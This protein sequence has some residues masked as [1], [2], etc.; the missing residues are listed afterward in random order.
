MAKLS[1]PH[2]AAVHDVGDHEGQLYIA[3]E[4]V[5]GR[6]LGTWLRDERPGLW[7]LLDV[8]AQAGRGLAAAHAAGL[9]HRDFKPAN[10]MVSGDG[11]VRVLDFGLARAEVGPH[12]DASALATTLDRLDADARA[13]TH[14]GAIVGTPAYM[15]PEQL[16]GQPATARSDQFAFCVALFEVLHGVRPFAGEDLAEL[17]ANVITGRRREVPRDHVPAWLNEVI[18]RGLQTDPGT[19]W[20][21]MDALVDAIVRG[22]MEQG[23]GRMPVARRR[24]G[25]LLPTLLLA[26]FATGIF[27]GL[28]GAS[29]LSGAAAVA[30]GVGLVAGALGYFAFAT[31][32]RGSLRAFGRVRASHRWATSVPADRVLELVVLNAA[33]RDYTID[34]SSRGTR[35]LC[36]RTRP[37]WRSLGVLARLRVD[38]DGPASMVQLDMRAL[39]P[40][41]LTWG[42]ERDALVATLTGLL[43]DDRRYPPAVP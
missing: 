27:V 2:V 23:L 1:H 13:I 17:A 31:Y 8:M 12:V 40:F 20:P 37:G 43:G 21:D 36:L 26:T 9:V 22:R 6:E 11:R 29:A 42:V 19:R 18:D 39:A 41:E 15:A 33:G 24:A 5:P 14:R 16:R 34:D 7:T 3:M 25:V 10:A 32:A 35:E 4:F 28:S 38:E 30:F